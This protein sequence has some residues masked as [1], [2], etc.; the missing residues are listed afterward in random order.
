MAMFERFESHRDV[1]GY[2]LGAALTMEH[3]WLA[4]LPLLIDSA[5][6]D[7]VE[8]L[9]EFR[10]AQ[11]RH[12]ITELNALFDM[13]GYAPAQYPS[14]ASS[15]L[16]RTETAFIGKCAP[17]L[18]ESGAVAAAMMLDGVRLAHYV[19]LFETLPDGVH[20]MAR[21][22][23]GSLLADA[24]RAHGELETALRTLGSRAVSDASLGSTREAHEGTAS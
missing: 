18:R 14:P 13:L 3:D 15:A 8:D 5:R 4:I 19:I 23:V 16:V 12:Q 17:A 9:F 21:V 2:R 10:A 6:S 11:T 1:Y 20:P 24:R 22:K 7:E